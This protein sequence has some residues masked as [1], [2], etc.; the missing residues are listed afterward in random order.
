MK[1]VLN[2][3]GKTMAPGGLEALV[4]KVGPD[5][6]RFNSELEKLITFVGKRREILA[7]DIET[8][9]KRTRQDPIYEMT[10]AFAERKTQKAMFFL[11]SLLN[12]GFYPLQAL[13]ALS[14]Q[15]RKLILAKDFAQSSHGSAWRKGLGYGG[16]QKIVLPQLKEQE[17]DLLSGG[18][19][20]FAVYN[21]MKQSDN[22]TLKELIGALEILLET[23]IRLKSSGQDPKT[24]LEYALL[25][26]CGRG[27]K[28]L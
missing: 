15:V 27:A 23:D 1:N 13:K 11:D 28:G 20:P 21:T 6:R 2:K 4:E 18:T 25:R 24:V 8:L 10:N 17:S 9:S 22:Y 14:N 19:H 3:T 5:V 12:S 7:S 26:I 16:F